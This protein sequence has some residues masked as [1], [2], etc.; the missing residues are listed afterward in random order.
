MTREQALA[1]LRMWSAPGR[2]AELI[3]AAWDAGETRVSVLAEAARVSRPTVYA[4]LRAKGIGPETRPREDTLMTTLT[5]EG[6]TGTEAD[7]DLL[8]R[9]MRDADDE[10]RMR[11]MVLHD[12]LQRQRRMGAALREEERARAQRDRALHLV[13]TRWEDL[14]TASAWL[15]AHHAYIV[16]VDEARAAIDAWAAVAHE[17]W[18]QQTRA[19]RWDYALEAERAAEEQIRAAGHQPVTLLDT[20]PAPVAEQLR[21]ELEQTH[22]HRARL[23]AQTLGV[24]TGTPSQ[25]P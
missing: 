14:S 16:A 24:A 9:R 3:A 13:E 6:F 5:I 8:L 4:D 21:A 15:A 18:K 1:E 12:V 2:R 20:D 25:T 23:T 10:E 22:A 19:A 7:A 17:T 11:L